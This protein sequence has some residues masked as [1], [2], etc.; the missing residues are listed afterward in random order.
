MRSGQLS[1]LARATG[2][3]LS[4]GA[5][6][7]TAADTPDAWVTRKTKVSLMTT[8]G[9]STKDLNV[10][11]VNGIVTLHGMVASEAERAKAESVAAGIDGAKYLAG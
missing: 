5:G 8:E 4:L 7:A 3:I 9:V 10:D 1:R 11:T 6:V 2:L